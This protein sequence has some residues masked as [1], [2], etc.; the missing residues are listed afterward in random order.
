MEEYEFHSKYI[1][2]ISAFLLLFAAL[3]YNKYC[4][5]ASKAF[6]AG[7]IYLESRDWQAARIYYQDYDEQFRFAVNR[8]KWETEK[9]IIQTTNMILINKAMMEQDYE[10]ASFHYDQLESHH[11][12]F[13]IEYGL[14]EEHINVYKLWVDELIAQNNL[15]AAI[16]IYKKLAIWH[17]DTEIGIQAAKVLPDL[18][19]Q[20]ARDDL[21]NGNFSDAITTMELFL[22]EYPDHEESDNIQK[23]IIQSQLDWVKELVE[24]EHYNSALLKLDTF[25]AHTSDPITLEQFND[26]TLH[27]LLSQLNFAIE[28]ENNKLA[29]RVSDRIVTDFPDA[30]ENTDIKSTILSAYIQY[31]NTAYNE[32]NDLLAWEYY[33]KIINLSGSTG[34]KSESIISTMSDL[35]GK[36]LIDG[37]RYGEI[38]IDGNTNA[39]CTGDT[40]PYPFVGTQKSDT[41]KGASCADTYGLPYPWKALNPQDFA[42]VVKV[43]PD[44]RILATC[45]YPTNRFEMTRID[46]RVYVYDSGT[47]DIVA[48]HVYEGTA[49]DQC[50]ETYPDYY[51]ENA[52]AATPSDEE[53]FGWLEQFFE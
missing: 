38:I 32:S 3:N 27:T 43:E 39:I 31:A 22:K 25:A 14:K 1:L 34:V 12:E 37:S 10:E 4:Q 30:T 24:S 16:P 45:E 36:L 53:I 29:T 41:P 51:D 11:K 46:M 33:N 8:Q 18:Y 13:A 15:K 20:Y 23:L 21:E 17:E 50:P 52:T 49:P 6:S 47:G 28:N 48:E 19:L 2:W 40:I 7:Q 42:Y 5:D 9:I 26:M 44:I 35:E